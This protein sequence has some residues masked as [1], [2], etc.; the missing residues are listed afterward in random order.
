VPLSALNKYS[1]AVFCD[2]VKFTIHIESDDGWVMAM[3]Y[4]FGSPIAFCTEFCRGMTT[5]RLTIGIMNLIIHFQELP[6]YRQLSNILQLIMF[7]VKLKTISLTTTTFVLLPS[8]FRRLRSS[9]T[10]RRWKPTIPHR[11]SN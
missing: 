9:T 1:P 4:C 6:L 7:Y 11:M 3:K 10:F 5:K 8:V 2:S